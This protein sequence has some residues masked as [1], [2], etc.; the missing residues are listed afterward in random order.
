MTP[1]AAFALER[2]AISPAD[3]RVM[4]DAIGIDISASSDELHLLWIAVEAISA[5]LPL[6][7]AELTGDDAAQ[8]LL[9]LSKAEGSARG[10][11]QD[12]GEGG[13]ADVLGVA[14]AEDARAETPELGARRE[15]L[16]RPS[17]AEETA[18]DASTAG[19][20]STAPAGGTRRA[21]R[22][23]TRR[24]SFT[25]ASAYVNELTGEVRHTHPL[26]DAF[27]EHVEHERK[28][29]GK[30]RKWSHLEGWMQVS[31]RG[32]AGARARARAHAPAAAAAD[33][34][35]GAALAR[36][37]PSAPVSL[38]TAP[39]SPTTTTCARASRSP[40]CP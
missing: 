17:T 35:A 23:S 33:A 29:K 20:D 18:D 30:P 22:R 9:K 4:G 1:R 15:T 38:P 32:R 10:D 27:A 24:S 3:V 12:E 16:E 13:G 14:A 5:P 19:A 31:A 36:P 25:A 26:L 28:S 7:W 37:P 21:P 40:S 2:E 34:P 11:G 8:A 6:F 39:A